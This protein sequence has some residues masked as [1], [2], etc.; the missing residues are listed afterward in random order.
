MKTAS[1]AEKTL[2]TKTIESLGLPERQRSRALADLAAANML[3]GAFIAASKL[4]HR[5]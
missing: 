1:N 5:R 2:T 4:L 3:V